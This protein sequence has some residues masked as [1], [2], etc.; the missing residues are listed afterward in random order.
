MEVLLDFEECLQDSPVFRLAVDQFESDAAVLELQINK[1][2]KCCSNMVEAGQVY[3]TANQLFVS[4]LAELSG[5][6]K[7]EDSIANCLRQFDQ[8]LNEMVNFHTIL[9]DQTQRAINHQLTSLL[10]QF[11]PALGEI[12]REFVRI[13]DDLETAAL[14]NAQVSRHKESDTERASHLLIATRK[15]YQHFAL[16]YCLQLNNFKIQQKVDILNSVFSYFH[17]QYTFFHQGFDLLKDLEPTMK[18]MATQLAQLSADCT[19]KRKDLEKHHLLVQQRMAGPIGSER[20]TDRWNLLVKEEIVTD[21]DKHM[22]I[23]MEDLSL[24]ANSQCDEQDQFEQNDTPPQAEDLISENPNEQLNIAPDEEVEDMDYGCLPEQTKE[25]SGD[26]CVPEQTKEDSADDCVL[27]LPEKEMGDDCVPELPEK[28]MGDDCVLELPEKEMGDDCVPE[29]P[30]KNM[31]DDCVL[32]LPEKEMGDDC[33]LELSEKDLGDDCFLELSEKELGD[34]CFLEL[35]E[36]ELGDDCF[37]EQTEKNSG[38]DFFLEQTEENAGVD[39]FPEQSEKDFGDVRVPEQTKEDSGEDFFL[40]QAEENSGDDCDP[41]QTEEVSGDDSVLK[42]TEK[43]S[44]VDCFPEQS[45]KDLGDVR[46]PEQTEEDS[47]DDFF[48]EL[49][50]EDSGDEYVPRQTDEDSGDDSDPE[51]SE[52]D[53]GDD[54]IP[55][56]TEED[57]VSEQTDKHSKSVP[58][59]TMGNGG[60]KDHRRS[61]RASKQ[62][63]LDELGRSTVAMDTKKNPRKPG[64][65]GEGPNTNQTDIESENENVVIHSSVKINGRR[66]S[67]LQYC[68][69]CMKPV[70]KISRHLKHTHKY[71][72]EVVDAFGFPKCS[73]ERRKRLNFLRIQGNFKHNTAVLKSGKGE[74][75]PS[76]RPKGASKPEDFKHCGYCKV[77]FQKNR[78]WHHSKS[79]TLKPTSITTSP[80]NIESIGCVTPHITRKV[81]RMVNAMPVDDITAAIRKDRVIIQVGEQLLVK[82]RNYLKGRKMAIE[83]MRELGGLLT[84]AKKVS[85]FRNM[86]DFINTQKYMELVDCVK[87]TCEYNSVTGSYGK[88]ALIDKLEKDLMMVSRML[89]SK[90]L[91]ANDVDSVDK[92]RSFQDVH[93]ERWRDFVF[94]AAPPPTVGKFTEDVQRLHLFLGEKHD[95]GMCELLREPSPESWTALV[96]VCL[97]QVFL[98]NYQQEHVVSSLTVSDFLSSEA[99]CWS[100]DHSLTEVQ[101]ILSRNFAKIVVKKSDASPASVLLTPK[102]LCTLNLIVEKREECGVVKENQ[103]LFGQPSELSHYHCSECL[104]DF[105]KVCGTRS[106]TVLMDTELRSHTAILSTVLNLCTTDTGLLAELVGHDL[107]TPPGYYCPPLKTCQLARIAEVLLAREA[108]ATGQFQGKCLDAI[109]V[110]LREKV[111]LGRIRRRLA[112]GVTECGSAEDEVIP[113]EAKKCERPKNIPDPRRRK[114]RQEEVQAVERHMMALIT[115]GRV[116]GCRDCYKCLSAEPTA[117]GHRDWKSIKYY[118]YN[119]IRALKR[120]ER[121][122]PK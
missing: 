36:K 62:K 60:W 23:K 64:A 59:A 76:R 77:L 97:T 56:Q 75:V 74:L 20:L 37:P 116:P 114:W 87:A 4:S 29:L 103:Y 81:W 46:V 65:G 48:Q 122:S 70:A 9:L 95:E 96:K 44:G 120:D 107:A 92:A 16:D 17:A 83:K 67:K 3:S 28:N 100:P 45:E 26:D 13:G 104:I 41:E 73:K 94:S 53:S 72:P 2:Q 24:H 71:L 33:V 69:F 30:E 66:K 80:R 54:C 18:T 40:K 101:K 106:P 25:Y 102:M 14:K 51:Q 58:E 22:D 21:E 86:E 57:C 115:S 78:L 15:C 27:E 112:Y 34:D 91:A 109:E 7:K 6:H 12:R 113:N 43:N 47:G 105:A 42:Q 98:F 79:C 88:R 50:E 19:V 68:L 119:R 55:K 93:K 10:N 85:S 110:N 49:S 8:G 35:L 63:A 1:V 5:L 61:T 121:T 31:G 38:D 90:A 82:C 11:F 39:I 99:T 117:L 111:F 84:T 118:V 32:E 52:E 108:G 89:K